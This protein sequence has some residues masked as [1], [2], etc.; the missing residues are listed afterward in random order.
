MR[1]SASRSIIQPRRHSWRTYGLDYD[2]RK[3]LNKLLWR[4]L[5][6]RGA[7]GHFS[8]LSWNDCPPGVN[9]VLWRE[10]MEF[11]LYTQGLRY[12]YV[13]REHIGPISLAEL[14]FD[15]YG[16][17]ADGPF[18]F[19]SKYQTDPPVGPYTRRTTF[20]VIV[21]L[22]LRDEWNPHYVLDGDETIYTH[23]ITGVMRSSD[24]KA[25]FPR[26]LLSAARK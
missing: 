19:Y 7:A 25:P 14:Y 17:G 18:T 10:T 11:Q 24:P 22:Y 13:L 6:E 21:D 9:A 12:H 3:P 16:G 8:R 5:T 26:S 4:T 1:T 15:R 2:P 20:M 23:K